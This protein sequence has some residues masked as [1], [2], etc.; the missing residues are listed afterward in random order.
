MLHKTKTISFILISLFMVFLY[1]CREVMVVTEIDKDGSCIRKMYTSMDTSDVGESWFHLPYTASWKQAI[2]TDT[3]DYK[4]I[5]HNKFNSVSD[6]NAE[7]FSNYN[8]DNHVQ[9]RVDLDKSYLGFFTTYRFIEVYRAVLP[10][11]QY[12]VPI[13]DFLNDNEMEIFNTKKDSSVIKD[14]VE[15]WEQANM[16]YKFFQRLESYNES[17]DEIF[18]ED[19]KDKKEKIVELLSIYDDQDDDE[20]FVKSLEDVLGTSNRSHILTVIDQFQ[21]EIDSYFENIMN[22]AAGEFVQ[23]VV[24]PGIITATNAETVVGNKAVWDFEGESFDHED[25]EMW[26]ESR[27][28]NWV[29]IFIALGILMVGGL[30]ICLA[31]MRRGRVG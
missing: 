28:V 7:L 6:L 8:S 10:L 25:F 21:S 15:D 4:M 22:K 26:V 23:V 17:H 2:L 18:G 11:N 24:M 31:V 13:S 1:G 20:K 19:L 14:K 30:L 3:T 29:F 27:R 16:G 5:V 9:S 12:E